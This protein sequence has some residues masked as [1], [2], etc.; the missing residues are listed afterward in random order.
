M[1]LLMLPVHKVLWVTCKTLVDTIRG[2]SDDLGKE[3]KILKSCKP[4]FGNVL[5]LPIYNFTVISE[6][7]D[8]CLVFQTMTLVLK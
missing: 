6:I 8:M 2:S 4:E 7:G 5:Q 3:L 1:C